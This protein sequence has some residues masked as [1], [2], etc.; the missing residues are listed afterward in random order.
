MIA[1]YRPDIARVTEETVVNLKELESR[2]E[3][4]RNDLAWLCTTLGHPEAARVAATP[5]RSVGIPSALPIGTAGL[6]GVSTPLQNMLAAQYAGISPFASGVPGSGQSWSPI[7]GIPTASGI[8]TG[9]AFNPLA[10]LVNPA[11]ALLNPAAAY[12][13]PFAAAYLNSLAAGIATPYAQN[14]AFR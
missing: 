13:N 9:A 4:L 5:V 8:A 14:P 10:S 7:A 1:Q 6:L 3:V 11:A 2:M 12:A